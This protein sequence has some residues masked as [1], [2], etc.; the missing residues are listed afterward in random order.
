M[1]TLV[2]ANAGKGVLNQKGIKHGLGVHE[3]CSSW[4]CR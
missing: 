4:F 2:K 3:F 1:Y